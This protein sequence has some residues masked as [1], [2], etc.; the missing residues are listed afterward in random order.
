[1][2]DAMLG[3]DA[4]SSTNVTVVFESM[5]SNWTALGVDLADATRLY[6]RNKLAIILHSVPELSTVDIE[7]TLKQLLAGGH[8]IWLTGTNNYANFDT[9][10]PTFIERLAALSG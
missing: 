2:E 4:R 1:M 8:S 10:F 6:D 5:F 3:V 9:R 7:T